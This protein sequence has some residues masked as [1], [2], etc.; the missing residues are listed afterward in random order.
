MLNVKDIM[1]LS[2]KP[3]LYQKDTAVMWTDSCIFKQ[4]LEVYLNPDVNLASR[5][6]K[7]LIWRNWI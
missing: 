5:K 3:K 2:V 7:T 6:E 1:Y 4:Q